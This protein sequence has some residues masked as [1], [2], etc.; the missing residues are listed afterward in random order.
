MSGQ[1]SPVG[2]EGDELDGAVEVE[3]P[4]QGLAAGDRPQPGRAIGRAGHESA[5]VGAEGR[6]EYGVLMS[7]EGAD[8]TARRDLEESD[9]RGLIAEGGEIPPIGAHLNRGEPHGDPLVEA[10][11]HPGQPGRVHRPDL[12]PCLDDP[13]GE[14]LPTAVSDQPS[15]VV[16]EPGRGEEHGIKG[17]SGGHLEVGDRRPERTSGVARDGEEAGL[18][19]PAPGREKPALGV[20]R[21]RG[22][23]RGVYQLRGRE[24]A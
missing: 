22:H 6:T 9:A 23:R 11:G 12:R 19:V 7:Q 20:E 17:G 1:R 2:R 14:F 15:A 18:I 3:R 16:D 10:G 21:E 8:G 5:T 4:G 24:R 13:Q